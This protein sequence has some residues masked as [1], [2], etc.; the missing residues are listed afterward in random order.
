MFD[1]YVSDKVGSVSC[2]A[3]GLRRGWGGAPGINMLK[4]QVGGERG[5]QRG[6]DWLKLLQG[7]RD[8]YPAG[9]CGYS[10]GWVQSRRP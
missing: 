2:W 10:N 1:T 6:A 3:W 5:R 9:S 7:R 8:F 4:Q